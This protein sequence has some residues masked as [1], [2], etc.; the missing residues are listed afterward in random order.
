MQLEKYFRN[1]KV[2]ITGH[3]G[4]KGTWLCLWLEMMGAKVK[5]YALKPE[6]PSLFRQVK[7]NLKVD[8]VIADIRNAERIKK[9]ITA[10]K[11]DYIFHLAAQPLV[12]ESYE[13]PLETFDVNTIGTAHVLDALKALSNK[14]VCIIVT[15]DKVYRNIEKDYAYKE[16]DKLG[17]YDP[18]SASKAAAEIVTESY[19]LSFFNPAAFKR[20]R[21][22]VASGRAGNVIGGGDYAKDRIVPD[23]IRALE[24]SKP[25]EVRN[26]AAIRPWQHVLE[27][28]GGYLTLAAKLWE[29]PEKFATSYN[30]GPRLN[31][32]F[33]VEELVDKALKSWPSGKYKF[34]GSKGHPHEAGL[35]KLDIRKAKSDLG[36]Q[37]RWT[38]GKAIDRTI[39]W[40]RNI[41]SKSA[42]D[43]CMTDIAEYIK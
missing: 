39:G 18:Y 43:R 25:V 17:G 10:F 6:D 30:F 35:L 26:P 2:F 29:S 11:A 16:S 5:G 34:A 9:E 36:W 28:L 8:S 13:I 23:I 42:F 40:Y 15:T 32:T 38:A 1:K 27:P 3:T 41:E 21:K 19:R 4:F 7:K 20:H 12:R 37:P 24:S 22:A 33:T 31:D 14:C